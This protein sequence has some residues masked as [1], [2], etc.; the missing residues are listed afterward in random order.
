MALDGQRP[1]ADAEAA[2]LHDLTAMSPYA[3]L[4]CA[5]GLELVQLRRGTSPIVD[6]VSALSVLS[7]YIGLDFLSTRLCRTL[8]V[9][10]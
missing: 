10:G 7:V 9:P 3:G 6:H 2:V 4:A 5:Q 1:S 8:E